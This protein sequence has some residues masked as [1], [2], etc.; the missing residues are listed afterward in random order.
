M[1]EMETGK[2]RRG[3]AP[4]PLPVYQHDQQKCTGKKTFQV[5]HTFFVCFF[6]SWKSHHFCRHI[7]NVGASV[8]VRVRQNNIFLFFKKQLLSIRKL[9]TCCHGKGCG[10]YNFIPF[11][12][13]SFS[14]FKKTLRTLQAKR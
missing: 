11:F 5:I 7:I 6:F 12:Y 14:L 13:V 3:R 8:Y 4:L 1:N 2:Q 10:L 9:F